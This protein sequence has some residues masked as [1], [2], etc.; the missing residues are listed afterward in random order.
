MVNIASASYKTMGFSAA[1]LLAPF[2]VAGRFMVRLAESSVQA[3]A[4]SG[5][6]QLSDEDLAAQ[7]RSRADEVC[8]IMGAAA[9]V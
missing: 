1:A 9:I 3:R 4:L 6:S 8:R 2:C 7:G 5:L